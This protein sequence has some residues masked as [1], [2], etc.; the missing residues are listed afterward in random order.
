MSRQDAQDVVEAENS[1]RVINESSKADARRVNTETLV[2]LNQLSGVGFA[3]LTGAKDFVSH[4][5]GSG[6][7]ML[8]FKMPSQ[9]AGKGFNIGIRYD[10]PTDTYGVEIQNSRKPYKT[11][12]ATESGFDLLDVADAIEANTGTLLSFRK[13]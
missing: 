7:G 8:T 12:Y 3:R 13:R 11:V 2:G 1:K 5:L 6:S 10:R 4:D 9:V